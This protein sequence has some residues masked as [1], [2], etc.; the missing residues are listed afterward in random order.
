MQQRAVVVPQIIFHSQE[1]KIKRNLGK[2]RSLFTKYIFRTF[3]QDLSLMQQSPSTA[4]PSSNPVKSA[5]N[6]FF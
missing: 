3:P 5:P 2:R 4:A 1:A 6:L